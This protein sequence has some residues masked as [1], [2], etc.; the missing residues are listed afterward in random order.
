M[1]EEA[2]LELK[3]QKR[4]Q[5]EEDRILK[6]SGSKR[7]QREISPE[8]ISDEDEPEDNLM[9]MIHE[10]QKKVGQDSGLEIEG[11]LTPFRRSLE[12]IPR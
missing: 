2:K 6:R 11:T 9:Q 1:E 10:L 5:E 7:I 4:I 12:S 3:V 8:L